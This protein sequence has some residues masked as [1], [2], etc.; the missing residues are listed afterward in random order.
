MAVRHRGGTAETL[1]SSSKT[2][3]RQT[4]AAGG[5]G[6]ISLSIAPR[7]KL[8]HNDDGAKGCAPGRPIPAGRRGEAPTRL[9]GSIYRRNVRREKRE[10][11]YW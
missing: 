8:S 6:Q 5:S 4:R 3:G 10:H 9:R 2:I 7:D 1:R 11:E